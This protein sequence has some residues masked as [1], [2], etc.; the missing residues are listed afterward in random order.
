MIKLSQACLNSEEKEALIR[1][2]DDLYLGMGTEVRLFEEELKQY[3]KREVVCVNTG[4]S[5]LHLAMQACGIGAGD[6]VLVPTIT[7]IASFQA[8][9]ATGAR[10]IACDVHPNTLCLDIQDAQKRLTPRTKVIMPVHYAGQTHFL[11]EVYFFAQKQG[12][13]VIEDAAHSFGGTYQGLP[14]GAKGD[15]VC[16]SFDGIKNITCGEG[17]AVTSSDK[18]VLEKVQD[19]RLLGVQRDTEKRLSGQRS[20]DFDVVDQGW[21]CHMSNLNAALGRVQLKKVDFL[22]QRRKQIAEFYQQ[23]LDVCLPIPL[24]ENVPHIFPIF[25]QK[26]DALRSA[27]LEKGIE[28]GLHYKPNHL[29]SKYRQGP[30]KVAEE[31]YPLMITLP[32]HPN[33]T[34]ENV[35]FISQSVI[36]F[37][38][39]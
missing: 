34:D 35:Y 4:T 16:F 14:V 26:R 13:R 25:V 7:Y 33:L 29:L 10:P 12:L 17:G 18:E 1:V 5:A 11:E 37:L 36:D 20:W 15:V 31:K 8:I 38:L 39:N 30:L 28:T 2:I 9:S 21:R 32:L 23:T 6:D 24:K 19:L 22:S 27:F 3:I